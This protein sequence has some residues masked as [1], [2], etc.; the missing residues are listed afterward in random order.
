MSE[1]IRGGWG[2]KKALGGRGYL[3]VRASWL[4]NPLSLMQLCASAYSAM[5]IGGSSRQ[6][7]LTLAREIIAPGSAALFLRVPL[8]RPKPGRH[9]V[10]TNSA[11]TTFGFRVRAF[12]TVRRIV[13]S[14][15]PALRN[16][17]RKV[18]PSLAPATQAN[19]LSSLAR[20]AAGRGRVRMSSAPN[21]RP[22]D[23]RT[24]AS[25]RKS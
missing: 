12:R 18:T 1:S 5:V 22:P 16:S 8:A 6:T 7:P 15:K 25:S 23:R 11:A 9:R 3:A 10:A 19:Q 17:S 4:H 2:V 24:R 20:C 14:R 21:T 13:A